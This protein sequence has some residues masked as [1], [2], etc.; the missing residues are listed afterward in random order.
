[1]N[2][3]IIGN[4]KSGINLK[5]YIN[6]KGV[7]VKLIPYRKIK[8]H[9]NDLQRSEIIFILTKDDEINRFYNNYKELL[10]NKKLFHFSGSIYHK[11][12]TSLHPIFA[13]SRK[14]LSTKE[15]ENIIF[16]S[17][18]SPALIKSQLNW[19]RNKIIQIN[20]LEKPYY[21]ALLSIYFNF[22]LI[23][24]E[25]LSTI[26]SKRF[27]IPVWYLNYAFKKN[28]ENYFRTKQIT[29]P[30]ERN[31]RSTITRHLKALKKTDLE[32]LY[33]AVLKLRRRKI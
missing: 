1:M 12:I 32:G 10:T 8:E 2:I 19:F 16:T 11:K 25:E 5:S 23:I 26:I 4:S 17:E 28:L 30:I 3:A 6:S 20:P 21:H 29:G 15:F 7:K 33:K 22:P 14:P 27:K 31:D 18:L 9:I 13:F 24:I